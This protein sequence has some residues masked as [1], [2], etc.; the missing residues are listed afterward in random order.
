MPCH[1]NSSHE[2][3]DDEEL[4]ILKAFS[5]QM[6]ESW[7]VPGWVG[8]IAGITHTHPVYRSYRG[9]IE[10][11]TKRIRSLEDVIKLRSDIL[12]LARGEHSISHDQITQKTGASK[13]PK[14]SAHVKGI[15]SSQERGAGGGGMVNVG[16]SFSFEHEVRTKLKGRRKL[17]S[18]ELMGH[19]Q[20]S[21]C[22]HN[23]SGASLSLL[24]S[25]DAYN[26]GMANHDPITMVNHDEDM[27][28]TMKSDGSRHVGL[29]PRC[30][31]QEEDELLPATVV[32]TKMFVDPAEVDE[33]GQS[34]SS[35]LIRS[36]QCS[37]T[38][39]S[40][41]TNKFT[42]FPAGTGD[43]CTPKLLHACY[44]QGLTPVAVLEFWYGSPP[45]TATKQGRSTASEVVT[46]S[47][48]RRHG[49]VYPCCAK[50]ESILG[51]MLCDRQ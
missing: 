48:S 20:R 11:L 32:V 14:Q 50:C 28:E 40:S 5:G 9:L 10:T 46:R 25:F 24:A 36:T 18:H 45:N 43:C 15:R 17:L 35:A 39:R 41:S 23:M 51:A 47:T 42:G 21:Y 34:K 38:S 6:S 31:K 26:V 4:V 27:N 12:Q 33:H 2:A 37:S 1:A 13:K 19:V 49:F 8:P 44:Q 29:A 30:H 7:H 16:L 22:T 3:K